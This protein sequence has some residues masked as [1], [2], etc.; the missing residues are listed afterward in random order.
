MLAETSRPSLTERDQGSLLKIEYFSS[1]PQLH[2]R[3]IIVPS[4]D[5]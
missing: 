3:D 5:S 2:A 4:V 1:D